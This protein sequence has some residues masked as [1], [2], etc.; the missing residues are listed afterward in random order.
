MK[1]FYK[2]AGTTPVAG[3]HGVSLDG[4]LVTAPG[5]MPRATVIGTPPCG[6]G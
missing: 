4:R 5:P 2:K 3:G 6:V 1:R